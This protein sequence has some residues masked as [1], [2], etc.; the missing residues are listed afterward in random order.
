MNAPESPEPVR[1]PYRLTGM[2][3]AGCAR[4]L[5][6]ALAA[7]EGVL[8]ASVSF[9]TGEAVV[10][11]DPAA[12]DSGKVV[13][14]V[15]TLG[16]RAARSDGSAPG[17]RFDDFRASL[18][19]ARRRCLLAWA[20]AGPAVLL[21][22][23]SRIGI[24]SPPYWDW[25]DVCFAVPV[26]AIAGRE[27]ILR[28]L[29]T[30]RAKT[31][32]ANALVAIG[33]LATFLTG[34]MHLLGIGIASFAGAS[35]ILMAVHLTG[36]YLEARARGRILE[37]IR[38]SEDLGEEAARIVWEAQSSM[39]R[40][41][42]FAGQM[43]AILVAV[44]LG[45]SLSSAL[46]WLVMPDMMGALGGWAAPWLPWAPDGESSRL[47]MAT[48]SAVAVLAVSCPCAMGLAAPAAIM[49][50]TGL[51]AKRGLL[52]RNGAAIQ[53]LRDLTILCLARTGTLTLGRPKVVEVEA[54]AGESARDV[55]TWA[56]SVSLFSDHP[57]A[58]CIAEKATRDH[59][60]MLPAGDF[61]DVPGKGGRA[62]V[63]GAVV[64]AG[65][66]AY[67]A[68]EGVDLKSLEHALYRMQR[69]AKTVV[70]VSRGGR[71]VGIIGVTD[72]LRPESVRA[73]KIL[74]R[75]GI[76]CVMISGDSQATAEVVADQC[77]I[78]RVLANVLPQE[79]SKAIARLKKETIGTVGMVGDGINDPGALAAA[80]LGIAFG[81]GADTGPE[82]AEV[83]IVQD[84]LMALVTLIQL[85]KATY[86]TIIQNL[87][88][89]FGYNL[90]SV[91]LAM[92]GLLHPAIA[93][94]GMAFGSLVVIGNALRLRK[95]D[96]EKVTEEV[97]RR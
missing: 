88:W 1:Q 8:S 31:P 24:W 79:R 68:G 73:I 59:C 15:E 40:I 94:M 66:P 17:D 11:F 78:E 74:K 93:A 18:A 84:D 37:S 60:D 33:V 9:M 55:L 47:S 34:P 86:N 61:E 7:S 39:P 75:M 82:V 5:E 81:A 57:V 2:T 16:F 96:P 35:A 83:L 85:G 89:A 63:D 91:P 14:A 87:C 6:V 43:A 69:E 19:A 48:F 71:P 95:F 32:D 36:R 77:G 28:G 12:T 42:A 54:V 67:L 46:F 13:A 97:M 21:T 92:V 64:L 51:A 80:D 10:R 72:T 27:T 52:I 90:I 53:R 45:L 76:Q 62:M 22:V 29:A 25:L 44:V 30:L 41:H 26:L 49:A 65:T 70:A 3:C 4:R 56:A 38:G 23:L 58:Q 50:G 20:L